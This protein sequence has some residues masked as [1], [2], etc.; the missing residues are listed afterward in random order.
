MLARLQR[1]EHANAFLLDREL[2]PGDEPVKLCLRG[3][4]PVEFRKR[5]DPAAGPFEVVGES[6]GFFRFDPDVAARLA[7]AVEDHVESDRLDEPHEEAIRD[8][9][10][11]DP[12]AFGVED[13]T[14]LPWIEIDFPADLE[15]ARREVLPRLAD[16]PGDGGAW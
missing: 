10:R 15:R 11:A 8:L 13:V 4:R 3:G 1:S 12:E 2:E 5:P 7:A 16:S 14:G 9:V 6:V